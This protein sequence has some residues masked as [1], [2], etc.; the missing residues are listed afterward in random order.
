MRRQL[1]AGCTSII[2]G[3]L[4]IA[5]LSA[6]KLWWAAGLAILAVVAWK[7]TQAWQRQNPIPMPYSMR[8]MLF[9][10]RGHSP[11]NLKK[12]LEPQP[13]ERLL[14]IGPGIGIHALPVA[15]ALLPGGVLDALDIQQEMLD[16]LKRRA[17]K[18]GIT[19]IIATQG[20]AR[21]LPFPDRTFDAAYMLTTLGEIP[22]PAA[23]LNE[24]RRVLQP[25]GRLVIAEAVADPDYI[26]LFTLEEKVKNAGFVL[27]R[28]SGSK[29]SYFALF[30]PIA[31]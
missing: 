18:Q 6:I 17:E 9:I 29:F 15:A 21:K 23:A 4:S 13:G 25:K 10:P 5:A 20:D 31:T 28:T 7:L 19:N 14:E 3:I 12:I 26:P 8:W 16:D 22:D 30:R 27:A 11:Q 1:W 24:V 2:A